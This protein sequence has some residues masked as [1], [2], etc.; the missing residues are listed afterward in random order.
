MDFVERIRYA[1]DDNDP[2]W[3]SA[4]RKKSD[5]AVVVFSGWNDDGGI[6]GYVDAILQKGQVG[7]GEDMVLSFFLSLGFL[8][9]EDAGGFSLVL[10]RV[11]QYGDVGRVLVMNC[12]GWYF[13]RLT[14]PVISEWDEK[15]SLW[16]PLLTSRFRLKIEDWRFVEIIARRY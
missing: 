14:I 3:D 12:T 2:A 4:S 11:N 7:D 15:S 6:G 1:F 9:G 5:L 10:L 8:L 16:E 13:Q